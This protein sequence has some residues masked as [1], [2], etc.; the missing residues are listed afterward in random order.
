MVANADGRGTK[1]RVENLS[2]EYGS[3]SSLRGVTS[4]V[5]EKAI[6]VFFGPAG[7]GKTT[8]RKSTV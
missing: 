4:E 3:K 1:I 5:P 8:D 6:S 7:G 2:Y